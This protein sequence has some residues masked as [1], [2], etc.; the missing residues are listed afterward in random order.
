MYRCKCY[1]SEMISSDV[2]LLRWTTPSLSSTDGFFF[3]NPQGG[4]WSA[5]N[6]Y[7]DLIRQ[8]DGGGTWKD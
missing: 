6:T 2:I 1:E 4:E 8:S 5:A 3:Q 7:L